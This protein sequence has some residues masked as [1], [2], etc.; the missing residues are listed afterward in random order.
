M[1]WVP[2]IRVNQ[3]NKNWGYGK[4]NKKSLASVI[5]RRRKIVENSC[6]T[7]SFRRRKKPRHNNTSKTQILGTRSITNVYPQPTTQL[8]T[9][10]RPFIF[11]SH[12]ER[13]ELY[14]GNPKKLCMQL[15]ILLLHII[16]LCY[17]NYYYNDISLPTFHDSVSVLQSDFLTKLVFCRNKE[18]IKKC[19]FFRKR[20]IH[21]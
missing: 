21:Y 18:K 9:Y 17:N 16:L 8:S 6:S 15:Y 20:K 19:I 11:T 1:D 7:C 12:Q 3:L 14:N 5:W 10:I 13:T 4:L 2:K